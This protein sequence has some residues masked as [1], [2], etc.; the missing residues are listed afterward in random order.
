MRAIA[1][2][3]LGAALLSPSSGSTQTSPRPDSTVAGLERLIG[4]W[5][6]AAAGDRDG[7]RIAHDYSWTV[8]GKAVRIRENYSLGNPDAAELDGMVLWNPATERV[9]FIAVAGHGPDQGRYFE[10]EYLFRADGAVE[11][12]YDVFY[13]TL[14]DTPGEQLGGARRRFREVY[15]WAGPDTV[16]ATLDWWRAGRWQPFGP[17][18][19]TVVRV[20]TQR[21]GGR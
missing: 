6:P 20:H 12:V 21:G 15:R 4:L 9:E 18:R 13:R 2:I 10:G 1:A 3:L 19:Y 8:G 14:A 5:A 7:K 17:G 11:R 16:H